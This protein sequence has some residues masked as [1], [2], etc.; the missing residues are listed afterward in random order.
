[1]WCV[2]YNS[3]FSFYTLYA[4]FTFFLSL[5]LSLSASLHTHTHTRGWGE[6]ER[7]SST[8]LL[9]VVISTLSTHSS[10]LAWRIL[11]MAEPGGQPSMG[12][13]RVGHNWSD[14]AAT[15]LFLGD[16]VG[17]KKSYHVKCSVNVKIK[18]KI[19]ITPKN[20]MSPGAQAKLSLG[21]LT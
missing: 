4:L 1:M 13:H 17:E 8:S 14:L 10:V 16:S 2:M 15:V 7:S 21:Q 6:V 9:L 11:G 5:P 12:L 3:I 20:R 19:N 18:K